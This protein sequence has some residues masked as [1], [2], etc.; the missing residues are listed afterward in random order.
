MYLLWVTVSAD[1]V[2]CPVQDLFAQP[3]RKKSRNNE[4]PG[5]FGKFPCKLQSIL[6]LCAQL[7]WHPNGQNPLVQSI[8]NLTRI[9]YAA[10]QPLVL[11]WSRAEE[12]YWS[13]CLKIA[14]SC[15]ALILPSSPLMNTNSWG[16]RK[17]SKQQRSSFP[18]TKACTDKGS[19][20]FMRNYPN[21]FA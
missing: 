5:K 2:P 13:I 14:N 6:L 19:K 20:A 17:V 4:L 10:W 9:S 3:R 21:H 1:N 11:S 7:P 16:S 8:R 12:T 15:S 18:I